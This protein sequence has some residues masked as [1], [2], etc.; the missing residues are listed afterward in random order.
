[1][2]WTT[3][4]RLP[5]SCGRHRCALSRQLRRHR[6]PSPAATAR[7]RKRPA[8]LSRQYAP[9]GRFPAVNEVAAELDV[10]PSTVRNAVAALGRKGGSAP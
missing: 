1:M 4:C 5:G 8:P 7:C 2:V 9:G 6:T 10:A 3:A